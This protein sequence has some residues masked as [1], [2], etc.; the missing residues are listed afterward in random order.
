MMEPADLARE[1]R[2]IW[3]GPSGARWA[4]GWEEIDHELTRIATAILGFADARPGERVLDVGCG[5]G[6]TALALRERVGPSGAVTGVDLSAPLLAIARQRAA[7]TDIRWLEGDATTI[8]LAPE[9][10][11][12]FS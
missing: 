11:L 8:A 5:H 4:A 6:T 2:E 3:N 1:Q 10:D 9:Y 12:V 7:G